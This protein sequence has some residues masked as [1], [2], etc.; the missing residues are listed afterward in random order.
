[1]IGLLN[2][3]KEDKENPIKKTKEEEKK[4]CSVI[5]V[6]SGVNW[7]TIF[8]T[9]NKMERQKARTK[10]QTLHAKIQMILKIWWL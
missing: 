4:A 5:T 9:R 7:L 3:P 2:P 8:G 10:E 6:K 1:M